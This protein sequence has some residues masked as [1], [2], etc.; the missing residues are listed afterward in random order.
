MTEEIID[1]HT[2]FLQADFLKQAL[3]HNALANFGDGPVPPFNDDGR[4]DNV[5]DP[6]VRI[7]DMDKR[8]VTKHVISSSTVMQGT[9]YLSSKDE[10]KAVRKLNDFLYQQWVKKYPKRFIGTMILPLNNPDATRKE[11]E[12][13]VRDYHTKVVELP[14]RVGDTYLSD[15]SFDYLW[16]LIEKYKLV[17]FVHPDGIRDPWY[18][19]YVMWNSI[20]QN[21][22]ETKFMTSMIYEG[23][24]D[25]FSDVD[26]VL[27]HGGG[28]LPLYPGRVDRNAI[29]RPEETMM[30]VELP[31]PSDYIT[32]FHYDLCLYD[33]KTLQMLFDRYGTSPYMA[34]SDYP[35]GDQLPTDILKGLK[36]SKEERKMLLSG[37][38]KKLLNS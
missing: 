24:M 25:K 16:K 14:V 8:G 1:F 37:T 20:G 12:R 32:H 13:M 27:T 2:H 19:K 29:Y 22:E 3:P 26:I 30:N 5:F 23:K 4:F 6:K 35:F 11:L 33:Q 38:A 15:N 36:L 9:F 7:Q 31:F 34:G 17:A 28:T 21:I 10:P 18:R